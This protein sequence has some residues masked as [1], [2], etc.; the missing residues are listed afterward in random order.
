[1]SKR[2]NYAEL[3][4]LTTNAG[5]GPGRTYGWIL[6]NPEWYWPRDDSPQAKTR[7]ITDLDPCPLECGDPYCREWNDVLVLPGA[8]RAAALSS[9][10]RGDYQGCAY[11]VSEC[12]MRDD[13]PTDTHL[14]Q[15]QTP[16]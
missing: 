12:E 11:H 7:L 8:N 5:F 14:N 16:A 13:R 9:L 10:V 6:P 1:M 4:Y 3:V 2:R 15:Y